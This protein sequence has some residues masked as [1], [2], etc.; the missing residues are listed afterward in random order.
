M[1]MN[2]GLNPSA[3]KTAIDEY[4]FSAFDYAEQPGFT[5]AENPVVF[6][7]RSTDKAAVI[8]EEFGGPGEFIDR[9]EEERVAEATIRSGNQ[10]SRSVVNY[11]KEVPIPK[12]YFDDDQFDTIRD[13][14]EKF[15]TRARTTRDKKAFAIFTGGF[16]TYTSNDGN[17]LWYDSHTSLNGDTIDNLSTG[18]LTPSTFETLWRLLVE[19]KSQDGEA[20]GHVPT[21]FLVPPILAP[22]AHEFLK[23]DLKAN[24][25]DNNDNY[26]SAIYPGLQIFSSVYLGSTHDSAGYANAQTAHYLL[27]QN[28]S[29]CR[30]VREGI[31]TYMT[32]WRNDRQLRTWYGAGFREVVGAVSWE[33]A[34]ASTGA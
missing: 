33:G 32:D 31:Y 17:Y 15:G 30:W 21:A 5:T 9:T 28:H 19:Q 10:V 24:T 4:F 22:D 3:V 11:N 27:S 29:I 6:K 26:F 7:Q 1:P 12:E 25:T 14:T 18:A 13:V 20:G 2:S 23:S 16:G 34:A 8:T